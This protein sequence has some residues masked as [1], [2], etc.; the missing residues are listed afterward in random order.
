MLGRKKYR[1]GRKYVVVMCALDLRTQARVYTLRKRVWFEQHT[2]EVDALE[3]MIDMLCESSGDE[4]FDKHQAMV[5]FYRLVK[6]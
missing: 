1:K 6:D 5:I 2:S 3:L 4:T